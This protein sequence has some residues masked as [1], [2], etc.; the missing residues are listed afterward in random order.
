[1][2]KPL[3]TANCIVCGKPSVMFSGHVKGRMRMALGNL[4]EVKV[5][6]GFCNEDCKNKVE[7]DETGCFG[8]Y[9]Q[10]MGLVENIF[11]YIR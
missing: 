10:D 5:L 2:S 3:G 8:T 11:A 4:V 9:N 7:S 6:A 1:M